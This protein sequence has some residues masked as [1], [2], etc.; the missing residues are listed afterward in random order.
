MAETPTLPAN[1]RVSVAELEALHRDAYSWAL[2]RCRQARADAADLLQAA[3]ARLLDGSARFDG[4]SSLR[5]FLFGVIERLARE[6]RRR[7]RLRALLLLRFGAALEP[8]PSMGVAESPGSGEQA[9]IAAALQAL[10]PRQRGVLELVFYRDCSI[11]EAAAVMGIP[12]GTARTHYD[13]G[14]KSLAAS[15]RDLT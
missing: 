11:E 9:R 14:K 4:Q 2:T 7:E 13:R 12:V 1:P 10:S 6:Q 3:Y 15:L 8:A 5:T